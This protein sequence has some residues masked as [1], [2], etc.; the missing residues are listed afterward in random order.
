MNQTCPPDGALIPLQNSDKKAIVD[1]GYEAWALKYT[2]LLEE[3]TGYAY[4]EINGRRRYMHD[5][6][7]NKA[8]SN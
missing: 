1:K 2:W 5:M 4:T 6:V 7:M 3:S 8:R